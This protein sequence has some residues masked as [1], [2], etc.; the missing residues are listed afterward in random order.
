VNRFSTFC[1]FF[2]WNIAKIGG[3]P[4]KSVKKDKKIFFAPGGHAQYMYRSK[5]AEFY[6]DSKHLNLPYS[7]K[8]H[9]KK[10]FEDKNFRIYTGGTI[11]HRAL[12]ACLIIKCGMLM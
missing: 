8:M 9:L 4:S 5:D 6:A 7:D 2:K 1:A 12:L 10:L 3:K 11:R